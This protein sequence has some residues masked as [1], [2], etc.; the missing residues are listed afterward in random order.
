MIILGTEDNIA[1]LHSYG[2]WFCDGTFDSAPIGY[3]LYTIHALVSDTV[4]IPLIFC[5]EKNK[6]E[7][8]YREIFYCLKELDVTLNPR[9]IMLDFERAAINA[10]SQ[11][12]PDA[13]LQGCF[14]HFGQAIWR[15][16][17]PYG[18][19]Q[20]YQN[21]EE[22][23]VVVKQFQ[24]LA[25]VPSIDVIPC[26]EEL[27]DSL[28]NQLVDDFSEF[29]HYFEKTWIGI[30]HHGRKRRPL[31]DIQLWNIRDR[32]ERSLKN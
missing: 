23:A 21:E 24:A 25:F 31:F 5:I 19:Q 9:S 7:S 13:E 18:L 10:V 22:F 30:E 32:I 26:Y 4:T 11:Y 16:I 1:A 6:N 15:H 29:L 17:Q 12:I 14:F 8:T 27:I 28:S 20:C 3:Q 2:N